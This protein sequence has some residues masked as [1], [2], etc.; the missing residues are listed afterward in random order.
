MSSRTIFCLAAVYSK[1]DLPVHCVISDTR[2][3]ASIFAILNQPFDRGAMIDVNRISDTRFMAS[4]FA[5]LNQPF[6]RGAMIDV[7]R[8][9]HSEP[10]RAAG[11]IVPRLK[12]SFTG[13]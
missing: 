10:P 11:M 9:Y 7:N 3:M 2:F 8:R 4:I 6:D 13:G 12:R 1:N 5:I